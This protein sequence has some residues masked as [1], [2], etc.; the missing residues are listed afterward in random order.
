MA[1]LRGDQ[2]TIDGIRAGPEFASLNR[3]GEEAILQN[4]SATGGLRG[5]NTKGALASFRAD[6][7]TK[8]INQQFGRAGDI[9]RVGQGAAGA[10]SAAISGTA[11]NIAQLL[12]AQGAATAGGQIA[13]ANVTSNAINTA[14]QIASVIKGF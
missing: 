5:G 3:Q 1:I 2:S 4:A 7:L 9:T 8:L 11:N 12:A 6:L 10:A 14:A 13:K